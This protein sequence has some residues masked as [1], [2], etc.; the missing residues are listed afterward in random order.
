MAKFSDIKQFPRSNYNIDVGLNYLKEQIEHYL[1]QGLDINPD[2]QR[3]HVWTREQ[4]IAYVEFV[5]QGGTMNTPIY[6][7][8]PAFTAGYRPNGKFVLVDGKQRLAALLAFMSNEVPAF[9]SLYNQYTDK[10]RSCSVTIKIHVAELKTKREVLEWYL[11]INAGGT[12]HSTEELGFVP[13]WRKKIM[14]NNI[15]ETTVLKL[16]TIALWRPNI[17]SLPNIIRVRICGLA[18]TEQPILG[19]GYIV[20]LLDKIVS[21]DYTHVVVNECNLTSVR[22]EEPIC[23]KNYL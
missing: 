19:H 8:C 3:P 20:E 23:A 22:K 9:G 13:C 11:A 14:K 12:L 18:H 5:L 21:Y 15:L 4:Q 6:F 17:S 7:N 10:I 1:D 16:G 2:F